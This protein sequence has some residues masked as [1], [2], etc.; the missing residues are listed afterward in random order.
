MR[1]LL[2]ALQPETIAMLGQRDTGYRRE[3]GVSS[4]TTPVGCERRTT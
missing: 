4:R 3:I 1:S 2:P